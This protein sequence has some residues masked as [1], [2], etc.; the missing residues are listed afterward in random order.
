MPS[1]QVLPTP[2]ERAFSLSDDRKEATHEETLMASSVMIRW[3]QNVHANVGRKVGKTRQR[4]GIRK[5]KEEPAPSQRH[6]WETD[7]VRIADG[8]K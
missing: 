3:K 7:G 6:V 2:Q 5:S 4:R 1:R 8:G